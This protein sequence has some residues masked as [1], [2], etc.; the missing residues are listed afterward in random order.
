M[1][2]GALPL[3]Y[4]ATLPFPEICPPVFATPSYHAPVYICEIFTIEVSVLLTILMKSGRVMT[5]N[6]Y[7][8]Y[9]LGRVITFY[10]VIL[11]V[12]HRVIVL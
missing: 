8:K 5:S 4:E 10:F 3:S 1:K 9:V 7:Q 2:S 11:L 12:C 6:L